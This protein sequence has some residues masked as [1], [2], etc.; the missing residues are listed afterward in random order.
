M[1]SVEIDIL[2][3]VFSDLWRGIVSPTSLLPVRVLEL[4]C[5]LECVI[6]CKDSNEQCNVIINNSFYSSS[7][8]HIYRNGCTIQE[9]A[10]QLARL[11][12]G[13]HKN[14]IPSIC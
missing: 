6:T 12:K 8:V 14:S 4:S 3:T 13:R 10:P 9:A 5:W 1:I 11:H 2:L 7:V